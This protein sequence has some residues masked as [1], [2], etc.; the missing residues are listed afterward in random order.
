MSKN[1]YYEVMGLDKSA[2]AQE[3]KKAYRKLAKEWHPDHNKSPEAET[4]FKEI[5]EA[6]DVLSDES[7]KSAY[8]QY[9]HA[10]VDGFGGFGGGGG[11]YEGAQGYGSPFD[12][13][14]IFN[15][16]F[17]GMGGM[18]GFEGGDFE[19]MF[20]GRRQSR[21]SNAQQRGTDLRYSV[22]L[23]FIEAMKGGSYKI[24]ISRDVLCKVCKG[25][26]AKDG[27]L[28]DCATCGG[29]GRVRRIQNSFIGQI[30]V[31]TDCPDCNGSGK[32]AKDKCKECHGMGT[33]SEKDTLTI[34]IPAGA[35]DGMSLRFRNGGNFTKGSETPGDLYVDITV[36]TDER[37]ERNGNDIYSTIH[38]QA[39]DA[40]LGA[41]K[42]VETVDGSISLKIPAGTQPGT[43]FRLKGSGAPIIGNETR[44][45][46]YVKVNVEIPTKLNRDEKKLWEELRAK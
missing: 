8:D 12:M 33:V 14:D 36:E 17:N 27:K 16:V 11:G 26:G 45:D 13:G 30:S 5:R 37:F 21:R 6:Y 28:S 44:G 9:G 34:K 38:I 23:N 46:Q 20:G 3:I 19:S 24:N 40:V 15:S 25:T 35:Y 1:D 22:K 7:K 18:G 43:V 29:Q 39:Y 42:D 10:G 2:S 32:T 31:V 4:K 41:V